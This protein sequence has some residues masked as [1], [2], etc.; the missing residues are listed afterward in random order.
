MLIV[1]DYFSSNF[2]LLEVEPS[3]IVPRILGILIGVDLKTTINKYNEL[4]RKEGR[5][6]VEDNL[7][8]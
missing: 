8:K 6:P 7:R 4:V 5:R 1:D 2:K 3:L